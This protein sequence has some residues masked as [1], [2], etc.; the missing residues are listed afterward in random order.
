[1][2]MDDEDH[3]RKA[4]KCEACRHSFD[5]QAEAKQHMYQKIIGEPIG[6]RYATRA[7]RARAYATGTYIE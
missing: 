4:H 1:M 6:V 5:T 2:H 3:W 7:S